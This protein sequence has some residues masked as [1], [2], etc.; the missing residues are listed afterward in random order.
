[1]E[2]A[3]EELETFNRLRQKY[4][5]LQENSN[6]MPAVSRRAGS[7]LPFASSRHDKETA[8]PLHQ[9]SKSLHAIATRAGPQRARG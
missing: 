4:S 8:P 5:S 7:L 3:G 6:G 2:L 9:A 1:M